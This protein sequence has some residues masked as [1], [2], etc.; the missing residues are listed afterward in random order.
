[1]NAQ[2]ERLS[3]IIDEFLTVDDVRVWLKLPSNWSVY[4]L[5][6][7]E[8]LPARR[9]GGRLRFHRDEIRRWFLARERK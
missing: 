3:D 1:M 6:R 7:Q 8:G 4:R 5:R 2:P 9:L